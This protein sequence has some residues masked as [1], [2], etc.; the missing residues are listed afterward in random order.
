MVSCC[1]TAPVNVDKTILATLQA[2]AAS[3]S[4]GV[5]S[6]S[7][8][9]CDPSTSAPILVR[10]RFAF[11]NG[12]QTSL[13]YDAWNQDGTLYTGSVSALVSCAEG[14]TWTAG[15]LTVTRL[16]ATGAGSIPINSYSASIVNVGGASGLVEGVA[17]A[18][19]QSLNLTSVE[20]P[21]TKVFKKLPAISYDG[22][23]TTL[24]ITY[25]S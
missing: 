5:D 18:A 24:S 13:V 11:V 2:I 3:L 17:L 6:E 16:S 22:T 10:Y 1:T 4:S 12:T 25:L 14:A 15:N 19:T 9:L 8:V 20:D 7:Q 23:G 21:V